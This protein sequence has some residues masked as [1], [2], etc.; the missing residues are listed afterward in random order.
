M[1]N[2][3]YA[4]TGAGLA[5]SFCYSA[6]QADDSSVGRTAGLPAFITARRFAG[7]GDSDHGPAC[8]SNFA[9]VLW[10]VVLVSSLADIE[11]SSVLRVNKT[12]DASKDFTKAA[13]KMGNT[14]EREASR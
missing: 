1:C 6:T 7:I 14:D 8:D 12:P 10:H 5:K 2:R 13:K 4:N 3:D 9:P 11:K